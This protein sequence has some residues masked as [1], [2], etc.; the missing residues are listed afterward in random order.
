MSQGGAQQF[1]GD[2]HYRD[3]P[4]VGYPGRTDHSQHTDQFAACGIRSSN[5]AAIIQDFV[6]GLLADKNLHTLSL[7]ATIQQMQNVALRAAEMKIFI[8][9]CT[10]GWPM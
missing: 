8:C 5:H 6:T 7:L 9:S 4:V 10:A 3:Y 1:R 2:I